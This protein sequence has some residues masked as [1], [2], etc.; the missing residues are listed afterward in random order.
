MGMTR[1]AEQVANRVTDTFVQAGING[2]RAKFALRAR[3]GSRNTYSLTMPIGELLDL[4]AK[5]GTD[6]GSL[7]TNRALSDDWVKRIVRNL[8]VQ[9]MK[10]INSKFILF[11][12]TANVKESAVT[13]TPLSEGRAGGAEGGMADVG[14]LV[15]PQGLKFSVADGQHRLEAF[16]RLL[17]E[18]DWLARQALTLLLIEESGVTQRQLDFATAGKTLPL[19]RALLAYF[20]SSVAIN[21]ATKRFIAHSEAVDEND[22]E[23]FKNTASGKRNNCLWTF[24]QMVSYVGAGLAGGSLVQKTEVLAEVFERKL[25]DYGWKEDGPEVDAYAQEMAECL[26]VFLQTNVGTALSVAKSRPDLVPDWNDVR[27]SSLIFKGAGINTLGALLYELRQTR[28]ASVASGDIPP[29]EER[30]W[31]LHKIREVGSWDWSPTADT[32][33]GTLVRGSGSGSRVVSSTTAVS[34]TVVL[35]RARLG[36]LDHV[37]RKTAETL[38]ELMGDVDGDS[39]KTTGEIKVSREIKDTVR[40]AIRDE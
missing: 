38:I 22:I 36:L 29:T 15:I 11:P 9:L 34:S 25:D 18:F 20:D 27:S 31:L 13:F 24:N 19:T 21:L 10:G 32:F 6:D 26:D 7:Q 40:M 4:V 17:D 33:Q 8:R 37:Q 14:I 23:S 5:T 35:I 1:V 12:I 3:Q 2:D 39:Q 28:T 16:R 30:D